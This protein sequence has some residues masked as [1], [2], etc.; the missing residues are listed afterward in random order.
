MATK[1]FIDNSSPPVVIDVPNVDITHKE[2][3]ISFDDFVEKVK[4][5]EGWDKVKSYT[6]EKNGNHAIIA[7]IGTKLF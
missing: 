1:Y 5:A 3:V 4:E 6:V 2:E 7:V